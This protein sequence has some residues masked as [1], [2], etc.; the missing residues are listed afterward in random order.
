[1][2]TELGVNTTTAATYGNTA[3]RVMAA[4]ASWTSCAQTGQRLRPAR[5]RRPAARRAGHLVSG[6]GWTQTDPRTP[7]VSPKGGG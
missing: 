1:M 3:G 5:C 4:S 2:T 7:N 6:P